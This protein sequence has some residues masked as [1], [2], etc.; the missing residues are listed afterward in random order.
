MTPRPTPSNAKGNYWLAF[1]SWADEN[2]LGEAIED[3]ENDWDCWCTAIQTERDR[4]TDRLEV[5]ETTIQE[6]KHSL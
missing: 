2:G 4:L 1:N 3:W 5:L 6:L